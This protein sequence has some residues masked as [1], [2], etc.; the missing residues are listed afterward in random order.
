MRNRIISAGL[1]FIIVLSNC[2]VSSF[3]SEVVDTETVSADFAYQSGPE[4]I[5]VTVNAE[6][7]AVNAAGSDHSEIDASDDTY[8]QADLLIS[9]AEEVQAEPNGLQSDNADPAVL[10]NT[11]TTDVVIDQ[12]DI[13]A[14]NDTQGSTSVDEKAEETGET[15]DLPSINEENDIEAVEEIDGSNTNEGSDSPDQTTTADVN[16]VIEVPVVEDVEASEENYAVEEGKPTET[17]DS[18]VEESSLQTDDAKNIGVRP[19]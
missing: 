16:D 10:D 18:N 11:E 19:L 5:E 1:A 4:S 12:I 8:E 15:A 3:A 6:A 9:A 2:D 14:E 7:N 13:P 17:V